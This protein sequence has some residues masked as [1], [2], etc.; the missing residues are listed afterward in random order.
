LKK[1]IFNKNGE[2]KEIEK[3]QCGSVAPFLIFPEQREVDAVVF[4]VVEEVGVGAVVYE[5]GVFDDGDAS[6][7][8]RCYGN[9]GDGESL[10]KHIGRYILL[11]FG[12]DTVDYDR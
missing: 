6:F 12:D 2:V 9:P 11:P 3:G 7:Y 10:F 5:G 1:K 4:P 8:L